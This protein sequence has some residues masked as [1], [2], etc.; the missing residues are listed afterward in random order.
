MVETVDGREA[1]SLLLDC[2]FLLVQCFHD[3][4]GYLDYQAR[5]VQLDILRSLR[6]FVAFEIPVRLFLHCK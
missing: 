3:L 2:H 5:L 1:K 6:L 4:S